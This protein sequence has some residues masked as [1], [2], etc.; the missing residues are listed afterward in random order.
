MTQR[1]SGIP[2]HKR[3]PSAPNQRVD[4]GRAYTVPSTTT[5]LTGKTGAAPNVERQILP[6]SYGEPFPSVITQ[7]AKKKTTERWP[8]GN[9]YR[10]KTI[11]IDKCRGITR[12][13]G[14]VPGRS[15]HSSKEAQSKG[16]IQ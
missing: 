13:P 8:L 16:E 4:T 6:K 10:V 15:N 5:R 1:L 2:S 12:A 14:S 3:Q 11:D 9:T 7:R